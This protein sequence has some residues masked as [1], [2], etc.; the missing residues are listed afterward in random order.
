[1]NNHKIELLASANWSKIN[2]DL[3]CQSVIELSEY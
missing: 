1:M 3:S 2:W